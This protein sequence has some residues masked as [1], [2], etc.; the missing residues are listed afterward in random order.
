MGK[1]LTP[2]GWFFSCQNY[3]QV[4]SEWRKTD[5]GFRVART[6]LG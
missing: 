3:S 2:L 6:F 4:S 5:V 1:Q